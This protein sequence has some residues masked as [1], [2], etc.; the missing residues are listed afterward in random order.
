M[1]LYNTIKY[2]P[3]PNNFFKKNFKSLDLE[4]QEFLNWPPSVI[5]KIRKIKYFYSAIATVALLKVV[6]VNYNMRTLASHN[7][8]GVS[9]NK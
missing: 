3:I 4:W 9:E 5:S 8:F 2:Y 7:I 1:C 6:Y